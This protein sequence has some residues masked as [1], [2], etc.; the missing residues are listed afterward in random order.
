MLPVLIEHPNM[1]FSSILTI[2]NFK[3]KSLE[4]LLAPVN[5]LNEKYRESNSQIHKD[6]VVNW[7][8]GQLHKQATGNLALSELKTKIEKA[9]K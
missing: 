1:D 5:Y 2:I 7:I 3:K 8:M 4:E 9:I 6:K